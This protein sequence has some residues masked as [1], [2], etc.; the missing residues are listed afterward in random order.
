VVKRIRKRVAKK[1]DETTD[2]GAVSEA[3]EAAD[4]S[5]VIEADAPADANASFRAELE[6]L[7]EDDFTRTLAGGMGWLVDNRGLIIAGLGLTA[8][9]IVAVFVMQGQKTSGTEEAAA[10]F[11]EA[12]E[13]YVEAVTPPRPGSDAKPLTPDER[14]ARIEKAAQAFGRTRQVYGDQPVSHL[15]ALGEAGSRLDLGDAD[16]ALTLYE[17]A[18]AAQGLTPMTRAVTLQG[19]AAALETKGDLD[20]AIA[21]WKGVEGVDKDAF[22]LMAGM[23]TGRLLEA[24]GKGGEA[25]AIY[26]RI[27]ADHAAGLEQ[28]S[29]RALKA[30]LER[31]IA[32]LGRSS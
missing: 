3:G 13:G 31:R 5:A 24:Q 11:G 1:Q 6:S 28:L 18:L 22:G 26:E 32:R 19:K 10:A 4:G 9:V 29:N 25:K 12:S 2:G 17:Q 15:S 16:K 20:G 27:Q 23:Q 8:V 7:A 21:A 30:D 14:T